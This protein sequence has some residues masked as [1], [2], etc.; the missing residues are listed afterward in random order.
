MNAQTSP[1]PADT[2]NEVLGL[3]QAL[4][5]AEQRLEQLTAG[6]VDTVADRGGRTLLLRRAQDRLRHSTAAKQTAILNALP[7]HI[8]LLDAR[9]VIVS[10][11]EA[12]RCYGGADVL[13]GPGYALGINYVEICDNRAADDSSEGRQVA[14]GIRSVLAGTAK[15]FSVEYARDSATE[16]RVYLLTVT[17]LGDD[18]SN[19]AVVM[20]L[21]VTAQRLNEGTLRVSELRF[22]QMAESIRDVF[23]LRSIDSTHIYYV[24]PAYERIWGRT[25]ES[26]YLNP[27]SWLDAIHPDDR[28][29]A[30]LHFA[31]NEK[32][33]FDTEFRIVRLD[34]G[35]RWINARG[36]PILDDAGQP[37]RT[38]GVISDITERKQ[39]DIRIEH[40]N[41]VYAVLSQISALSVRVE[42]RGELFR[43]ACRIAVEAGAFRM[44]WIGVVNRQT[45]E[46]NVVAWHGG[47][48]GYIERIK[49]TLKADTPD[50]ERPACRA[51]RLLKPIICN[52]IA[53]DPSIAELR[54]ELLDRGHKSL[55]CFPLTVAGRPDAVLTLFA[56][57]AHA[58]NEEEMRLL[59]ELTR[60]ISFALDHLDKRERLD[61]LAYYDELTGLAN[62]SLFLERVAQ[63]T[64]SALH[65]GYRLALGLID[66]ERFKNINLSLGRPVGDL[67][68]KQ[69]AHWLTS[70]L[71]NANLLAR[72]GP[73]H[74]AVVFP[75]VKR[76]RDL[77]RHIEQSMEAFS[78]HPFSL[79]EAVFHVAAKIGVALFP[80][81]ASDADALFKNAEI[82]LRKAKVAGD[83]YLLYA[84]KMTTTV[85][86]RLNLETKLRDAIDREEFVLHYQP[87]VSL[88]NRKLTGAEALIRWND[89]KTGLVQ[90]GEFISILEDTGLIH[91]VGRWALHRAIQD[92]LH[93][94][95]AGL[96]ATRIAVNVSALQLRSRSFIDELRQA[97]E[98]DAHAAAGLELEITEGLIMEDVKLSTASL[99]AIRA[100]G[101]SVAIDD[102]GTGFSS[103]SYLSKLPVDTLKIDRSFVNDMTNTQQGLLLVSTII[104]LAHSLKL[105]VVAEGVETAVQSDLLRTLGCDEMQGYFFSKPVPREIFA[106]IFL[107]SRLTA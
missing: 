22:R 97:I 11:N 50:S 49:L 37:Y 77:E 48:E 66:L 20:L 32:S 38:A 14:A 76:E 52:D 56:A 55:G 4:H 72:V 90:P 100:M 73:D 107:T 8:A 101:V 61:Y 24:S 1:F 69:V 42:D 35:V 26:L 12:W 99:K 19:G 93:W 15:G 7:A 28:E 75:E 54:E 94:R 47:E 85:T 17:S 78:R 33:E 82:A 98:V 84:Q 96:P 80:D 53:T 87:K 60:N 79:N 34:G 43:E 88:L 29:H 9:G 41:R 106:E 63:H 64:R 5:K 25:C 65:G 103:L 92:H 30:L 31:K 23:F 105:K 10:A 13:E 62:R 6:E 44:A 67:L 58:F 59:L 46:G 27:A 40:L 36:A 16:Q 74:F 21:D 68:L 3:I 2:T 89:P 81:D 18:A 91:E 104:T 70:N 51:L 71:G 86:G 83:R 39:A 45:L 57:E 102:L 95:A